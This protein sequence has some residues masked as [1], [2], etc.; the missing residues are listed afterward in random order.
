VFDTKL[1]SKG[2]ANKAK[3]V[4][5]DFGHKY[6][7]LGFENDVFSNKAIAKFVK[8]KKGATLDKIVKMDKKFISFTGKAE[9]KDDFFIVDRAQGTIFWDA[10]GSGAKAQVLIATFKNEKK[11]GIIDAGDFFFV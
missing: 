1:S 7:M 4:I 10:D 3:D 6:D 5:Y 8:A 2:V 11:A 9:D